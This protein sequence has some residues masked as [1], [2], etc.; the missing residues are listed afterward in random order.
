LNYEQIIPANERDLDIAL[1]KPVDC[2]DG[3]WANFILAV[4]DCDE[5]SAIC[6]TED[7]E[8]FKD[9]FANLRVFLDAKLVRISSSNEESVIGPFHTMSYN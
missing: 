2:R 5:V 4:E 3:V 6:D 1:A 8:S 7:C 9:N